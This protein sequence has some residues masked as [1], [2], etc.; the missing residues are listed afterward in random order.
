MLD[1]QIH[2]F[3]PCVL[4]PTRRSWLKEVSEQATRSG[5]QNA[6]ANTKVG[7]RIDLAL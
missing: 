6:E 3:L 5:R 2:S 4:D 7:E 1:L